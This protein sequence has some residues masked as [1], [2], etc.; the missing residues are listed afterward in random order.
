MTLTSKQ[1]AGL[2]LAI[3]RFHNNEPYT[4]IAGYAGTGKS[5]LVRFII[6]ALGIDPGLVAYVTYTGKAAQV[7]RT[8]GCMTAKTAHK[9]LYKSHMDE[10]TGKFVHIPR[11]CLEYNYKLI[12]VDEISMLPKALWDLLLTH[13]IPV[14]ALGDPGQLPP[15]AAQDTGVLKNPHIFLD[16]IMRQA[17]ESE[18]IRLTM[19]IRAGKPLELYRGNEVRVIDTAELFTAN[20][21]DWADQILVGKNDTRFTVNAIMRRRALNQTNLFPVDGD[22]IICLKNNWTLLNATGDNLVN[23]MSGRI[24]NIR[25]GNRSEDPF[26]EK[27]IVADFI[28][29]LEDACIFPDLKMDECLFT[30]HRESKNLINPNRWI[31]DIYKPE[32]FDYGYAITVHKAQGSEYDNVLVLEEFLRS[33]SKADHI[34]WLYTAATRAAKKLI[35]VKN[36]KI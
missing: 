16:E 6:D 34:K 25:P 33:E 27:F 21:W 13:H 14:L 10:R 3:E 5:T 23:G 32:Q 15:V 26:T 11:K 30:E 9:L 18:I 36:C 24:E 2:K 1:E 4:V 12:V 35:I 7:L 8:K 28:P 31:P 29:D 19:D 17:E 20:V 22:R